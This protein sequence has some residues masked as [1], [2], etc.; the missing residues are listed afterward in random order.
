MRKAT[1]T[2]GNGDV[3]AD[4]P[5]GLPS[6]AGPAAAVNGLERLEPR[7]TVPQTGV[8]SVPGGRAQMDCW[9]LYGSS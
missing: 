3:A 9:L 2:R 8:S 6:V 7:Q 5:A 4:G 1:D